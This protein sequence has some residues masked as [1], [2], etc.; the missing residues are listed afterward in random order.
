MSAMPA[1]F[2]CGMIGDAFWSLKPADCSTSSA[3]P[4]TCGRVAIWA[5]ACVAL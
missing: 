2:D 3:M 4:A 1:P 5:P